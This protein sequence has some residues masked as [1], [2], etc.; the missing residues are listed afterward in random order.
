ME[1][2]MHKMQQEW[3]EAKRRR[4]EAMRGFEEGDKDESEDD[5]SVMDSLRIDERQGKRSKPSKKRR[6]RTDRSDDEDPW[7]ELNVRKRASVQSASVV[8]SGRGLVGLHDVVVAPPKLSAPRAV[9]SD[10]TKDI[11]KAAGS[12][13]RREEL[14]KARAAVVDAIRSKGHEAH[15]KQTNIQDREK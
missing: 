3:R 13:H 2:K 6:R 15:L 1:K 8:G 5:E 4:E 14:S 9:F 11:P 10:M 7:A 12:L